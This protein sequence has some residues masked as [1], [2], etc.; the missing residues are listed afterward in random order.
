[1][2]P[3]LVYFNRNYC[4][5]CWRKFPIRLLATF[6]FYSLVLAEYNRLPEIW[7][8]IQWVG[9]FAEHASGKKSIKC[10]T[11]GIRNSHGWSK[12]SHLLWLQFSIFGWIFNFN[13]QLDNT[14]SWLLFLC[15][16]AHI[17]RE[18]N[19][20]DY[21]NWY[22]VL[23]G[24]EHQGFRRFHYHFNPYGR[25]TSLRTGRDRSC[26]YELYYINLKYLHTDR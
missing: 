23:L 9:Q 10:Q 25:F 21:T 4:W 17:N 16:V 13:F 8:R 5:N 26:C 14:D 7:H 24:L 15:Q 3:H 12:C 20:S 19:K 1:M 2:R 18:S 11:A 6:F 22:S